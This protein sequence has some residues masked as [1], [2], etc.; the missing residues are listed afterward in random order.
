M[1]GGVD[2]HAFLYSNSPI[3]DLRTLGGD[4][5]YAY[6]INASGRVVG[7]SLT[8]SGDDHAFPYR[9]RMMTDL[10]DLLPA[11][12]GWVLLSATG[13][14][15]AGQIVGYGTRNGQTRAFLLNLSSDIHRTV[16]T[17]DSVEPSGLTHFRIGQG[18]AMLTWT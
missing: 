1:P 8:A 3:M 7:D 13:I 9:N 14:N 5:S 10:H 4:I 17:P 2:S 11:G 12:S 15:N 18:N 6:G 16:T